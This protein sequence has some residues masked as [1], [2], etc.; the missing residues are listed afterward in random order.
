MALPTAGARTAATLACLP[1]ARDPGPSLSL[2]PRPGVIH[3]SAERIGMNPDEQ[4]E[5]SPTVADG[6]PSD[7]TTDVLREISRA[8]VRLYKEQFGRGPET[9]STHYSGP[10]VIVSLL[11]NSLTPVERTMREIGEAQRLRDIRMMFQHATEAQFREA[12]ESATGRAVVAFMSG[13]DVEHD[14]S[15]EVFML[16]PQNR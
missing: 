14:V 5:S 12:V 3:G 2:P 11:G 16:A 9:V 6:R 15:C 10:D 13:I 1:L 8:M 7:E 4:Q